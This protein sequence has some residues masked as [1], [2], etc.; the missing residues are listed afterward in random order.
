MRSIR[1]SARDFLRRTFVGAG[2]C[3]FLLYSGLKGTLSQA[4]HLLINGLV[5][6]ANRQI[7]QAH[8]DVIP[9]RPDPIVWQSILGSA[10]DVLIFMPLAF[11]L[12]RWL[13]RKEMS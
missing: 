9:L 1:Y 13:Y 4:A 6:T 3:V 12:A 5:F 8:L 11:L 2:I 7:K 10:V